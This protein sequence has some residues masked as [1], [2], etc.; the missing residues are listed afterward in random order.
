MV[1]ITSKRVPPMTTAVLPSSP[2]MANYSLRS[3]LTVLD[4][5]FNAGDVTAF[6]AGEEG[7]E[8]VRR[9][10]SHGEVHNRSHLS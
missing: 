2:P 10:I 4:E 8:G 6:V 9:T 7:A 5:E 3:A 1:S